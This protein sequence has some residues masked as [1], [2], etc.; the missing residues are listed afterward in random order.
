MSDKKSTVKKTFL[1]RMDI[2]MTEL[3][4]GKKD[5]KDKPKPKKFEGELVEGIV[6]ETG[7]KVAAEAFEVG[8][9][10][11]VTGDEGDFMPAPEGTHELED[12]T[13]ITVDAAGIITAVELARAPEEMKDDEKD[14]SPISRKEFKEVTEKLFEAISKVNKAKQEMSTQ[15]KTEAEKEESAK[16]E[17][18][19][20]KLAEKKK[21]LTDKKDSDDDDEDVLGDDF[22]KKARPHINANLQRCDQEFEG[23]EW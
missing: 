15:E 14:D 3:L 22:G 6:K 20:L 18:L 13:K 1:E 8:K 7:A 16:L 12:G 5:P 23:F 17:A 19:K 10:L 4:D 21:K 9:E 11:F 2:F